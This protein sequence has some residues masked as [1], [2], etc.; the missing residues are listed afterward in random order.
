MDVVPAGPSPVDVL[1]FVVVPIPV[2]VPV[3]V[4]PC[5]PV[6][7]PVV[8][9]MVPVVPVVPVVPPIVPCACACVEAISINM[10]GIIKIFFFMSLVL[11]FSMFLSSLDKLM[12]K[13]KVRSFMQHSGIAYFR[14]LTPAQKPYR[15][16]ALA[17]V[18]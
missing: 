12:L 17:L 4:V 16:Q 11:L 13:Q 5:R 8:V 9:P 14:Y 7:P 10:A 15:I 6:E 1:I 18:A 2:P 3:A